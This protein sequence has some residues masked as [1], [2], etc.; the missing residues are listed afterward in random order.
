MSKL[1]RVA[2]EVTAITEAADALRAEAGSAPTSDHA[3]LRALSERADELQRR[4]NVACEEMEGLAQRAREPDPDKRVYG[5]KTAER[6]LEL[7]ATLTACAEALPDVMDTVRRMCAPLAG[8]EE[9]ASGAANADAAELAARAEAESRARAE[10]AQ[11]AVRCCC[12]CGCVWRMLMCMRRHKRKQS[13]A[14]RRRQRGWR[15][16]GSARRRLRSAMLRWSGWAVVPELHR[17]GG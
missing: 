10:A 12:C 11:R 8:T 2:A 1:K 9:A 13:I 6:I 3:A 5:P 4:V 15:R 14:Q 16:S 7:H 17:Q